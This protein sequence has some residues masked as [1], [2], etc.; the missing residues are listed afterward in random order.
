MKKDLWYGPMKT[1]PFYQW[2]ERI[3]LTSWV[4]LAVIGDRTR[5]NINFAKV[6]VLLYVTTSKRGKAQ[7]C[8]ER[9]EVLEHAKHCSFCCCCCGVSANVV[10][11]SDSFTLFAANAPHPP[12]HPPHHPPFT[13]ITNQ[14]TFSCLMPPVSLFLKT[15]LGCTIG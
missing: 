7:K 5:S 10:E 6:F 3:R 14:P 1:S 2:A 11:A 13:L 4:T 12:P 9:H 15:I 8:F